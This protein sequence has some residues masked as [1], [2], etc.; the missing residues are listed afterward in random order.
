VE[1]Y[2]RLAAGGSSDA[3]RPGTRQQ[4]A[5]C[6]LIKSHDPDP[7]QWTQWIDQ[8]VALIDQTG[9]YKLD[10]Y[11]TAI[12]LDDMRASDYVASHQLDFDQ[13]T[14]PVLGT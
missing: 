3:R 9:A 2:L 13:L 1:R 8:W 7:Q 12:L 4:L 11:P 10:G 5:S 6:W 14:P